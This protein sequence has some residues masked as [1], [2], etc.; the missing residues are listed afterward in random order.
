MIVPRSFEATL[1]KDMVL[2]NLKRGREGGG[3]KERRKEGNDFPGMVAH[4]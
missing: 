3:R 2:Q 1:T 4:V